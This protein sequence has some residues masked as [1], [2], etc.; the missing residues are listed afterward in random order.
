[1]YVVITTAKSGVVVFVFRPHELK[2]LENLFSGA[3]SNVTLYRKGLR[4]G[5]EEGNKKERRENI[6]REMWEKMRGRRI[7][8][9]KGKR[10][11]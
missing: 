3:P 7:K 9:R 5:R 6:E 1:L 11:K 4:G 2:A 10:M 8:E